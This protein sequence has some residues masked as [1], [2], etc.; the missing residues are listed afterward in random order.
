MGP[1]RQSAGFTQER[2]LISFAV[3]KHRTFH[4]VADYLN[5]LRYPGPQCYIQGNAPASSGSVSITHR[6]SSLVSLSSYKLLIYLN[7]TQNRPNLNL[8]HV[9]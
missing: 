3:F 5:R 9:M 8:D 4:P 6:G 7:E 2:N 1:H